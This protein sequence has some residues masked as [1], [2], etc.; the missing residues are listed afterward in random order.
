MYERS[1][2]ILEKYFAEKFGYKEKSNLKNNYANFYNLIEKLGKYLEATELE[3]NSIK[4]Y[5]EIVDHI[6]QIQTKQSTLYKKAIKLQENRNLLFE[7][8][9]EVAANIEKSLTKIEECIDQ[10]S[11]EMKPVDHEYIETIK[12][13]SEKS[14]IRAEYG[15]NRRKVEKEYRDTL[16]F[17]TEN[18]DNID[19]NKLKEIKA[20]INSNDNI[21]I[22]E[23]KERM[24]KNGEKEAIPFNLDIIE[25]AAK[26]G[27]EI[28]IKEVKNL[29]AIYEKTHTL[30]NDINNNSLRFEK[31]SKFAKNVKNKLLFIQAQKEYLVQ[32]LDNERLCVSLGKEEHEKLMKEAC[33]DFENDIKQIK[34]LYALLKEETLG[35]VTKKSYRETY[36]H[37]YLQDL[38]KR[39][40]EFENEMKKLNLIGKIINPIF[41]RIDGIRNIYLVFDNIV[42]EDY[43]R[44]LEPY[45][46]KE[47]IEEIEQT[48]ENIE[49]KDNNENIEETLEHIEEEQTSLAEEETE[50]I[51]ELEDLED[52]E[53][54]M[55]EQI[56][57]EKLVETE[58][59]EE[60]IE[61]QKEKENIYNFEQ[62][63]DDEDYENIN[64]LLKKRKEKLKSKQTKTK[65][66][67]KG[68]FS[69]LVKNKSDVIKTF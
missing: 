9:D 51:E 56:E 11:E 65:P 53:E 67:K 31:H 63:D 20:I 33:I 44:D 50:K 6:K 38:E 26:L 59:K 68:I 54:E 16:E 64:D 61:A 58:E 23:L 55:I 27:K 36:N 35:K 17:T 57:E 30:L 10:N 34:N 45:K 14:K 48:E 39:E 62:E 21:I 13:F 19:E 37:Q 12:E 4:E 32:F 7:N 42:Q 52:L 43:G 60:I 24:L 2:I 49:E 66:K 18:F 1:A 69:K 47:T 25:N 22:E 40:T 29:I 15:T 8:I 3:D 28:Y 46:I 5:E 41:W